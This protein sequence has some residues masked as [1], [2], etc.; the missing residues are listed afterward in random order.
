MERLRGREAYL[1]IAILGLTREAPGEGGD[2]SRGFP[3]A[4]VEGKES[5]DTREAK[6]TGA[7][8]GGD[9]GRRRVL[10]WK[11]RHVRHVARWN[12]GEI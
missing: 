6:T 7:D 3:P 8:M 11:Q 9:V 4:W 10:R 1:R 12:Y 5:R 2:E